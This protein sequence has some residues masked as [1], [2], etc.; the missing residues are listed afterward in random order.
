MQNM[1]GVADI[2]F[3]NSVAVAL[4]TDGSIFTGKENYFHSAVSSLNGRQSSLTAYMVGRKA[5][6]LTA[7][8]K[9]IAL[10]TDRGELIVSGAFENGE[11]VLPALSEGEYFVD[12]VGGTR[13]F[14]GV[15]NFKKAYAWGY[16]AY[17]QCTLGKAEAEKVFFLP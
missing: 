7:N 16:N 9:C 4:K 17:G 11:D 15:T 2:V 12:I 8:S 5:V 6:K 1:Q 13:H 14:V 3:T 10:L